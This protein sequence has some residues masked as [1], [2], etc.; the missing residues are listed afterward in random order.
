[1]PEVRGERCGQDSRCLYHE[2]S[3]QVVLIHG[4]SVKGDYQN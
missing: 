2:A 4:I 3:G 1:M